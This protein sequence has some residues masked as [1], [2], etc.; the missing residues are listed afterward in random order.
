MD[1]TPKRTKSAPVS[2]GDHS[3]Q[4]PSG[5][6]RRATTG[7]SPTLE[8]IVKRS[9][10]PRDELESLS[11]EQLL[12]LTR[13]NTRKNHGGRASRF[14]SQLER[15][16]R[17]LENLAVE[18]KLQPEIKMKATP[19]VNP[20]DDDIFSPQSICSDSK[21]GGLGSCTFSKTDIVIGGN[22]KNEEDDDGS[23]GFGV[24]EATTEFQEGAGHALEAMN[25][26]DFCFEPGSYF[27]G[28][29]SSPY[30][31]P[32]MPRSVR[33]STSVTVLDYKAY[34]PLSVSQIH[35][36]EHPT[37]TEMRLQARKRSIRDQR[38]P[39]AS[40]R[41]E[42]TS[43]ETTNPGEA[44]EQPKQGL[45]RRNTPRYQLELGQGDRGRA[46]TTGSTSVELVR[47]LSREPLKD[48]NIAPQ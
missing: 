9:G 46:M 24:E 31:L 15:V 40:T 1:E 48:S 34:E 28:S 8:P 20:L 44:N 29:V 17:R 10:R 6:L 12:K 19:V 11:E 41:V 21:T 4:R 26:E 32:V 23:E 36:L 14:R 22:V 42:R 45:S 7:R 27:P 16:C 5:Q 3:Q 13:S 18:V 38:F 35:R 2:Y 30:S 39:A 43:G 33:I 47:K 37:R 25:D